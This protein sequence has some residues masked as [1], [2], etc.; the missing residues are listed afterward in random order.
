MT[1]GL[2]DTSTPRISNT[3]K[4]EYMADIGYCRDVVNAYEASSKTYKSGATVL[5]RTFVA[6]SATATAASGNTGNGTMGTVTVSGKARPGKYT[7]TITAAASNAGSFAVRDPDGAVI[8]NG[9]V[10]AAYSDGQLSFTLA[11]GS[12]DFVV[13]DNFTIVVVGAYRYKKVE[14]TATDGS[15][16]AC[17]IYLSESDAGFGNATIAATTLTPIVALVRGPA[18][19]ARESLDY[20]SSINTTAEKNA[21]YAQ[22]EAIGIA[23]YTQV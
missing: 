2:I 8:G 15:D 22:L 17:A 12:A 16:V 23:T 10:A 11:D 7:V 20:G 6:T 21:L 14:D 19:V 18:A 3:L 1:T 9:T 5:G 4:H 13:G